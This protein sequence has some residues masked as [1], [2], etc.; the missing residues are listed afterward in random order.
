MSI[1][2]KNTADNLDFSPNHDEHEDAVAI[3]G[4]E[5]IFKWASEAVS[6][7]Q[8]ERVRQARDRRVRH[9]VLDVVQ[10]YR[11]QRVVTKSQDEVAYLQRR[12]IALLS[13]MQELTEENAAVKQIMV[14]QF[15]AIQRIPVLEEQVRVLKVVEYEKD[16]AV[17]E[18]RYLMDALAKVKVERDYLEDILVTCEDENSRLSS[19][20]N[21]TRE[22]LA[23]VQARRW[24]HSFVPKSFLKKG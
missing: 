21:T 15:W 5:H 4:L 16:A 20:L 24:W 17:K 18:R 7:P 2:K 1:H 8:D 3:D 22:E 12:V 23:Q 14:S 6:D 11:E 19:I 9:Q 10:K 13:K